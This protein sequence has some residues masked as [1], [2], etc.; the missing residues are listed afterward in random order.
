MLKG[1]PERGGMPYRFPIH[2]LQVTKDD[3]NTDEFKEFA[4]K[5]ALG[6][7]N[8]NQS[9]QFSMCCRFMPNGEDDIIKTGYFGGSGGMQ[10]GSHRVV[11]L[12]LPYIAYQS[13][14]EKRSVEEIISE[15]VLHAVRSLTIHKIVLNRYIHTNFLL[16][17]DIGW[18]NL[19]QL[20]S[21]VGFH[22][23]PEFLKILGYEPTAVDGVS[24]GKKILN[25]I[26]IQLKELSKEMTS[27]LSTTGYRQT[28]G[29][30]IN[31]KCNLEE[32]PAEGSTSTL[33][34]FNNMQFG[35][36]DIFYSNQFVPLYMNVPMHE[37]LRIE[38]E[39]VSSLSGGSMTF[40]NWDSPLDAEQS[41]KIHRN[42]VRDTDISQFTFNYGR[43]V[44][45]HENCDTSLMGFHDI[46]PKCKN[47]LQQW[48]RVVGY[49][50]PL[51]NWSKDR[52]EE[53]GTRIYYGTD[54]VMFG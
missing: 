1:D 50:A 45:N 21:T 10:L 43:S 32:V 28:N 48:T 33:A 34:R 22:G 30:L 51:D 49:N 40:L 41:Y 9:E 46:C 47:K 52:R 5:N 42:I 6:Y 3:V 4:E 35:T 2:T 54:S 7:F 37:R 8:V 36:K 29:K 23:F 12:N 13:L 24:K 14:A 11:M 18:M 27:F 53:H 17:F 20:Y 31:I 19:D 44:C 16:F 38:S 39:L 15:S 25:Q 26:L